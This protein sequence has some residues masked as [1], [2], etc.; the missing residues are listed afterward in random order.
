MPIWVDSNVLKP[1]LDVLLQWQLLQPEEQGAIGEQGQ[2][3]RHVVDQHIFIADDERVA[4]AAALDRPEQIVEIGVVV[5]VAEAPV[6]RLIFQSDVQP[7]G[8][9]GS[10]CWASS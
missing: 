8:L 9:C 10:P 7:L 6:E 1:R 4:L 5:L 2:L 3:A